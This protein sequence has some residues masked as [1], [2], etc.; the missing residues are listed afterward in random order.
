LAAA[1]APSPVAAPAAAP[2]PKPAAKASALSKPF[3]QIGIFSVEQ[4]AKNTA[5]AMRQA[6][7]VPTIK[8]GESS[9]K[10]FWRVVVGPAQ[11]A[12]ERD[13]LLAKVKDSGF[14]DAYA[15]SD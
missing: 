1:P 12:A 11:T 9:G 2:A 14:T 6:G 3:L 8:P 5:V 7:M 15:V 4:N 10:P 13:Q